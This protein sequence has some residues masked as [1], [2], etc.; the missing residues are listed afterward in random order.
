M[1]SGTI[2]SARDIGTTEDRRPRIR[3]AASPATSVIVFGRGMEGGTTAMG[4]GMDP[5]LFDRPCGEWTRI[6]EVGSKTVCSARRD[7]N[8]LP[9]GL[10]YLLAFRGDRLTIGWFPR[11]KRCRGR[12]PGDLIS[13]RRI[14]VRRFTSALTIARTA[15]KPCPQA[16]LMLTFRCRL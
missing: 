15:R 16:F 6:A 11:A 9:L 3:T 1:L 12:Q 13:A 14:P 8:K 7:R 10:K 4:I 2:D 5:E